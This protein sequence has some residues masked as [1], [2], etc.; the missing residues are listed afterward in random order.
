M[1]AEAAARNGHTAASEAASTRPAHLPSLDGI[2]AGAFLLVFLAH[3]GLDAVLPGGFG[4]TVFFFLS[5]YLITT[6]LRQ[7]FSTTGTISLKQFYLRR[8]LRILPPFYLVLTLAVVA[9]RW[10]VLPGGLQQGAVAAQMLQFANYRIV[11]DGYRGM[12]A[13]TGVY[14]SLAVEEHFYL[15]FPLFYMWLQRRRLSGRS[16]AALLWSLCG[17]VL[18]WRCV[19][20]GLFHATPERTGLATDTRIDSILFGCALA[21]HGNPSLDRPARVSERTLKVLLLPLSA[22]LLA[23]TFVC[24]DATFRE[25]FRYTLQGLGLYVPMVV[26][27]RYP[28]W[29]PVRILNYRPVAFIGVLSYSLYLAHHVILNV[30]G[31]HV[32]SSPV[33]RAGVALVVATLF[34]LGSHVAVEKPCAV[35]RKRLSGPRPTGSDASSWRG[36]QPVTG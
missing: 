14:W 30:V 16:Q 31:V 34:A 10:G 1:T 15:L 8:V 11:L 35:L 23:F 32:T 2:R 29:A 19:L 18:A 22:A 21:V 24:R 13:G 27:L 33:V 6:L 5:G 28:T 9:A 26:A 25:T 4:V 17:V 7:E 36:R 20:V 3:A 12:P